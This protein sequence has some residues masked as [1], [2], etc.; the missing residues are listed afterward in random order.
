MLDPHAR[1]LVVKDRTKRLLEVFRKP[2]DAPRDLPTIGAGAA[3]IRK[4]AKNGTAQR[5]RH[6]GIGKV[7]PVQK[8]DATSG[9]TLGL[10]W[11]PEVLEAKPPQHAREFYRAD[12]LR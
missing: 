4:R 7:F 5:S 10:D 6:S 11:V 9:I 12:S 2:R 3:L 8:G 1:V